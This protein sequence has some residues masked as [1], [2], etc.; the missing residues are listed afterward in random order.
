MKKRILRKMKCIFIMALS[1]M[2]IYFVVDKSEMITVHAQ[3]DSEQYGVTTTDHLPADDHNQNETETYGITDAS[4]M[5]VTESKGTG[6]LS[7]MIFA[8]GVILLNGG[9]LYL[10]TIKSSADE[11]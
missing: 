9:G 5:T 4:D 2:M 10:I 1:I 7:W 3:T 8:M 11:V 6:L